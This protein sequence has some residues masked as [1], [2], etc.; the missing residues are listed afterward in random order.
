M[1]HRL[2]RPGNLFTS[3]MNYLC[4]RAGIR[5]HSVTYSYPSDKQKLRKHNVRLET[6][7]GCDQTCD[8]IV[9]S[10]S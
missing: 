4:V 7:F 9:Y 10:R 5:I 3:E 2:F 6:T 8:F 1:G